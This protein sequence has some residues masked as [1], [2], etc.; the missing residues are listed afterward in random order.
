MHCLD[1]SARCLKAS[2][3]QL[4]GESVNIVR[5]VTILKTWHSQQGSLPM[6]GLCTQNLATSLVEASH[7]IH[8]PYLAEQSHGGAIAPVD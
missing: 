7:L 3:L 5:T 6:L 8:Q 2:E 4:D 1:I